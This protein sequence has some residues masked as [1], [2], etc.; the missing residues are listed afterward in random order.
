MTRILPTFPHVWICAVFSFLHRTYAHLVTEHFIQ[1]VLKLL[2]V[3]GITSPFI[4]TVGSRLSAGIGT[5][6]TA[7]IRKSRIVFRLAVNKTTVL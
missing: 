2:R 1:L 3:T 7:D 4:I 6:A 5:G